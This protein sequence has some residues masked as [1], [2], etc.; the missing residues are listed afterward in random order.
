MKISV[1]VPVKKSR[2][3]KD[4]LDSLSKQTYKNF[5]VLIVGD[6]KK[7]AIPKKL[8]GK[9]KFLRK[10]KVSA[11]K[12]RNIGIKLA[13][14][15]VIAFTDS[16]CRVD[17]DWLKFLY[18]YFKKGFSC[19]AGSVFETKRTFASRYL[20]T[21][22]F[23]TFPVYHE[24]VL[25]SEDNFH[26][27]RYPIGCN[28]AFRKKIF[29]KVG[30]FDEEMYG[31]EEIDFLWKFLRRGYIILCTPDSKVWHNHRR[32]II[33]LIGRYFR[34]GHGCGQFCVKYPFS[35]FAIGRLSILFLWMLYLTIFFSSF[36]FYTILFLTIIPLV[37]L[38]S[39]YV[40]RLLKKREVGIIIYPFLDC[41]Y[42]FIA[43]PLGMLIGILKSLIRKHYGKLE[44]LS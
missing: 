3:L 43:Y 12:A 18:N 2:N 34:D 13:R 24:N 6:F 37:V 27:S 7:M 8:R 25:I 20:A 31:Y 35:R 38:S 17:K 42:C 41:L 28:I 14:G 30:Y 19:V 40:K 26:S 23:R 5:E 16:D 39:F 32:G 9:I 29:E 1:I 33:T 10:P 11:N 44:I 22:I 36:S 4:L 21:S 15:S